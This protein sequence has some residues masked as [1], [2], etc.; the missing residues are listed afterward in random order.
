VQYFA[1]CAALIGATIATSAAADDI[2]RPITFGADYTAD[3]VVVDAGGSQRDTF[4]LDNLNVTADF[5][6]DRLAGLHGTSAH[7]H[8]LNNFGGMP[9]DVANT[10]QGISNIEVG[11]HRLRLFEAWVEQSLGSRATAR[12]GLYDL[13][14]EF[15]SNDASKLLIAPAFGVGSEIAATGPNGPSIFPSTALA[16]RVDTKVG[17]RGFARAA[18][19]NADARTIG[20]PQGVDIT[21]RQ[22]GLLIIESGI[23]RAG[24]LAFGAWTY[25][26]QQNDIREV[27]ANGSPIGRG[28]HGAYAI[29]EKPL[30]DQDGRWAT[31]AFI[32]LGV[33]EGHTTPFR[34][35]WQGGL[36]F[37]HVIAGRRDGV[38]SVGANQA[39]LAP[40]YRHL[41]ADDGIGTSAAESA[42][43]ITYSDTI[44]PHVSVQPDLQFIMHPAGSSDRPDVVA[45]TVRMRLSY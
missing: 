17:D 7:V 36:L 4:L 34:G 14:S 41:L 13:N 40:A 8:M 32:R 30:N 1:C 16:L 5:D 2:K 24:K 20:D 33:S 12:I 3:A 18:L 15:Y 26:K 23:E 44:L 9:N 43:E 38:L 28:A 42:L 29:V 22:G 21:F 31:Q 39:Y 10:L 25:T 19:V 27:D 11:S 45:L 6:L 35:G 37:A